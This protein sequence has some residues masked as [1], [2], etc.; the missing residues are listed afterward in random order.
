MQK[1][2]NQAQDQYILSDAYRLYQKYQDQDMTGHDIFKLGCDAMRCL[3]WKYD[4]NPLAC[5]LAQ[6]LVNYHIEKF[7]AAHGV[8]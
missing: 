4:L 7:K 3:T 2:I 5:S 8:A 1:E 6:A